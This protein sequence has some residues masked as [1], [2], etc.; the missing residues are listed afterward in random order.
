ML[1][2]V[3]EA[4]GPRLE[5]EYAAPVADGKLGQNLVRVRTLVAGICNTDLEIARGYMGFHGVLGHEFVGEAM[6]GAW[7]GRRVVGGINF[8]CGCCHWCAS[9]LARHCPSRSVLGIA[10]ADGVLAE[11]FLIPEQNLLAVPDSVSDEVAAFAEPVGAACEILEQLG[12][13][14]RGDALVLGAGKLGAVVAQVLASSGYRVDLV[15]RH[16]DR[17]GWLGERGVRLAGAVPDRTG[18]ALVVEATGTTDGLRIAIDCTRPRGHLVLKTTVAGAHQI[19][20]APIVI[21]E[22]T[23]VGSRCGQFEPALAM[24]ADGRVSVAPLVDARYALEDVET[25]FEHAGRR[26]VRKVLVRAS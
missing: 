16:L 9:G 7:A 3:M 6:T 2:F 18:Y 24:L 21:N 22:I 5:R 8:G 23:I 20:L 14:P 1:A 17:V 13:A 15:G 10:G 19:D 12:A 4:G 11:E 25:A 26:G